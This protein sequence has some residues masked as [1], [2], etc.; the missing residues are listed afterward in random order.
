MVFLIICI[1]TSIVNLLLGLFVYLRNT[2]GKSNRLFALL[3]ASIVGWIVTLLLYYL[4]TDPLPLLFIGRLNFAVSVPMTFF[5]YCL[6]TAFPKETV[7]TPRFI[8]I[9]ALTV[10]IGCIAFITD[11]IYRSK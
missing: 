10:T 11:S 8:Y 2:K 6:V 4:I 1:F 3:V 7:K 9:T 5:F